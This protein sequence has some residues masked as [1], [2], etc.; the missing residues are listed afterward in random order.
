LL[1]VIAEETAVGI[2]QPFHGLVDA[3][4][5][6][7][8]HRELEQWGVFPRVSD[9]IPKRREM[10]L[11]WTLVAEI[12]EGHVGMRSVVARYTLMLNPSARPAE[13]ASA[14]RPQYQA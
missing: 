5:E 12:D 7:S 3:I 9:H 2:E 4:R 10:N 11:V 6:P 1:N 13:N 8:Q 14:G